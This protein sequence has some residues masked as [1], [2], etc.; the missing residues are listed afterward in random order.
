MGLAVDPAKERVYDAVLASRRR[1]Q[2]IFL[3][4]AKR[5]RRGSSHC[6]SGCLQGSI[7]RLCTGAPESMSII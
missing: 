6:E 2:H 5:Q 7:R 3:K 4:A 1:G